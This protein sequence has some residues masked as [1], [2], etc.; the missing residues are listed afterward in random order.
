MNAADHAIEEIREVRRRISADFDHDIA[1]YLAHLREL[2]KEYPEQI[3]R[4]KE[5]LAQRE[6]ERKKYAEKAGEPLA[7][8]DK[9]KS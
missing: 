4:G 7:L 5:L 1:K 8:R 2:E 6:A 9:P 3:R